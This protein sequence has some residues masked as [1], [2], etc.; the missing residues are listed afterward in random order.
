MGKD[1]IKSSSEKVNLHQR[2]RHR[3]R[4]DFKKLIE[5]C[6]ELAKFVRVNKFNI[7]S[8]D[9]SN[10]LAVKF[11][12][13]ALLNC[14]YGV[15]IWDIPAGYLCPPIPGRADYIHY[16][17]D[18]LGISNS[19]N[20]PRG[21]NVKVLDIGVGANCV[22]PIIGVSEYDWQFV[23]V[24]IDPMAI[25]S[26][27]EIIHSNDFLKNKVECRLQGSEKNILKNVIK[28]NEFFDLIICNPPFHASIEEALAGTERK[29][30]NL[31]VQKKDKHMLNFGGQNAELW[32]DGGEVK[33]VRTMIEQSPMFASQCLWF[34]S[35]ISKSEHLQMIY[36]A[37][38]S[39]HAIEVKTIEM[40]Q[41]NKISRFVAWT[42]FNKQEQ[43][44]WA[45]NRWEK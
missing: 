26:A 12:N 41:G 6:P 43:K 5:V 13:E 16:A 42:F 9:F 3:N 23:G 45:D 28:E 27:E 44:I 37:L 7:E 8:I 36:E 2:N 20:F 25:K 21:R 31:K 32:C 38:K 14:F 15:S 34:T 22:Y 18:L 4:Y 10:S 33:F 40:A 30:R 19:G 29:W 11:L 39:V 35:L 24:D 1:Q 17:A